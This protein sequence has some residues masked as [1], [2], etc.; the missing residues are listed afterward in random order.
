MLTVTENDDLNWCKVVRPL[1][2]AC[3]SQD[4]TA[5]PRRSL[6]HVWLFA[7]PWT[8]ARQTPLSLEF[9]RQYYWSWYCHFL[10]QGGLLNPGIEPASPPGASRFFTP[11]PPGKPQLVPLP[12]H[13]SHQLLR[14]MHVE[15]S[16]FIP[17]KKIKS[18][19]WDYWVSNFNATFKNFLNCFRKI[20]S[21]FIFL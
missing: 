10:L 9:P 14:E 20:W 17:V 4:D 18:H 13:T 12:N 6:S 8:I 19:K 2:P 15:R 16:T 11:A 21:Q 3:P 7:T 1:L 5:F